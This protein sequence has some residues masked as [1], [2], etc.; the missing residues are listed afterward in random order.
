MRRAISTGWVRG[1]ALGLIAL[2][3]AGCGGSSASQSSAHGAYQTKGPRLSEVRFVD[4]DGNGVDEG[5]ILT[6]AFQRAVVIQADDASAFAFTAAGDTLGTAACVSQAVPGSTRVEITLGRDPS[7]TPGTSTINLIASADRIRIYDLLKQGAM[8]AGAPLAVQTFTSTAPTLVAA[9][10]CDAN[11]SGAVDAGDT[12]AAEFDKP[13]SIPSGATVAANFTL[14]VNGDSFGAG[15]TVSAFR[16][17]AQN[18]AAIIALGAGAVMT[19]AGSFSAGATTTGDP[20]G[21]SMAAVPTITDT[22]T[23][24][25]AVTGG[26]TV[27][28]GALPSNALVETGR[29][30]ALFLGRSDGKTPGLDGRFLFRP[31][32]AHY[33]K[34]DVTVGTETHAVELLFV[35]DTANHRVLIFDGLPSGNGGAAQVILGQTSVYAAAP[36]RSRDADA[37][38]D[39][40]TLDSPSD[41]HFDAAT[42]QLFVSDTGNHRVLIWKGVVDATDGSVALASGEASDLIVGQRGPA[43]GEANG[44]ESLASQRGLDAPRGI[45]VAGTQLAVCDTGN[46]RVLIW[47][48]IPDRN[49]AEADAVLGQATWSGSEA[50]RGGS[51][52][53]GTLSSPEGVFIDP[54]RSIDGGTT[55]GYIAVAD[56]GNHRVVIHKTIAPASGA[57]ADI[58][59]GQAGSQTT[60]AAGTAADTFRSP[61]GVW[62]ATNLL[63]VAD[64]GNHRV[65]IFDTTGGLTDASTGTALG[66]ANATSGSEQRGGGTPAANAFYSP[67]KVVASE[68]AGGVHLFVVDENHHRV[69]RWDDSLPAADGAADYVQGQQNLTSGLPRGGWL[70]EP[71]DVV[72]VGSSLI[73]ADRL[74]NRVLIWDPVPTAND[75]SPSVAIGQSDLYCTEPNAGGSASRATLYGPVAVASDGTRL[76]IADLENHRVL[77]YASIPGASGV[78][79]D[80]LLGQATDSGR[81]A[82]GGSTATAWSLDTPA[83]VSIDDAGRL[84][85]ADQENHRVVIHTDITALVDRDDADLVVGQATFT[86]G[87]ANEGDPDVDAYGLNGPAGVVVA[88]TILYVADSGNH[89]VLAFSPAPIRSRP[90]ATFAMGQPD[91]TSAFAKRGTAEGLYGPWSLQSDGI[92]FYAVDGGDNRVI[93]FAQTPGHAKAERDR[94]LG[95]RSLSGYLANGTGSARPDTWTLSLPQ[96]VFGNGRDTWVADGG[97]GRVI[98]FR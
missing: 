77:V 91:L 53:A 38:P 48:T 60:A 79:A 39:G 21:I 72:I 74:A 16:P 67:T 92:R 71:A 88:D 68:A 47:H 98:L 19:V 81:Y 3:G 63:Y 28:L 27:D 13:I 75:E 10:Y 32:G 36:N 66:Q 87:E 70:V 24:A 31:R 35:A 56:T 42:N 89:R 9:V 5:D 57:D 18:R 61:T 2:V 96:G 25:T 84:Y 44:G 73:V 20:T 55:T 62:G 86:T 26:T 85:I 14:P 95:Q 23:P 58:V 34:G 46:H 83:D 82:N 59:I 6:A 80:V 97:N 29:E 37:D 7:F 43:L 76:A 94:V 12:V 11:L 17:G 93:L 50:N 1:T 64:R 15:A 8:P 41:V 40:D 30:G 69:L 33:Y 54:S 78:S 45:Y 65:M 49:Y 51:V 52:G 90:K 22:V 4:V